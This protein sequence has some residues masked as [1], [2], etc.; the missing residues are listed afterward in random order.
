M[1]YSLQA[2]QA[3]AGQGQPHAGQGQA[4]AG[5]GHEEQNKPVV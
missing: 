4:Q 5:Q 2:Q 3:Q 1:F